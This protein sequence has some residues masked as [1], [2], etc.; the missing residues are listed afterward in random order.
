MG[1]V[2]DCQDGMS[3]TVTGGAFPDAQALLD[4]N[5]N[6][7]T[8]LATD[9]LNH[10]NE[11]TMLIGLVADMPE[12]IDEVKC[13]QPASYEEHFARSSFRGKT[14][15]I[16]AYRATAPAVRRAFEDAVMAFDMAVLSTIERLEA[17][18]PDDYPRIAGEADA[19]FHPLMARASGIIHG[20]EVDTDI[21]ADAGDQAAIDAL[22][23]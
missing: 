21:F 2:T 13:W 8:G 20:V 10:F 5:I 11:I 17:A 19:I 6:P 22:F 23:A 16:A 1:G 3:D 12:M 9:Y 14:L 4:A 18:A 7:A 15:A